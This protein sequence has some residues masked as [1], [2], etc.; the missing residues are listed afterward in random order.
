MRLGTEEHGKIR[1]KVGA[2]KD[3]TKEKTLKQQ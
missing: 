3:L 1:A 2:V